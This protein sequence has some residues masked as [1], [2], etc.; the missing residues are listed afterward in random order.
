M[1][2]L[3]Q[4]LRC[5]HSLSYP[6]AGREAPHRRPTSRLEAWP[7]IMMKQPELTSDY[8]LSV[9]FTWHAGHDLSTQLGPSV[10]VLCMYSQTP[11]Q[12]FRGSEFCWAGPRTRLEAKVFSRPQLGVS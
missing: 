12:S 8:G 10:Q 6:S 4:L 9:R 5:L 11:K 2:Q 1:A 7:L 3:I